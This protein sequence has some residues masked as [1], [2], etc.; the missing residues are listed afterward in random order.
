M[1]R[2]S[3]LSDNTTPLNMGDEADRTMLSKHWGKVTVGSSELLAQA[4]NDGH[5]ASFVLAHFNRSALFL[6]PAACAMLH[7]ACKWPNRFIYEVPIPKMGVDS[8]C[9]KCTHE[10]VLG[11]RAGLRT[12]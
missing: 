9:C 1:H 6:Y 5:K 8:L 3:A 12:K 7:C 11:W 4:I 10:Y 2:Y